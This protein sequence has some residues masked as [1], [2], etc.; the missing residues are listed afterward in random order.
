MQVGIKRGGSQAYRLAEQEY[1][2]ILAQL[3]TEIA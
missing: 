2:A 1:Y 3:E